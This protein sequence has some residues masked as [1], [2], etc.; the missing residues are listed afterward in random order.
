MELTSVASTAFAQRLAMQKGLCLVLIGSVVGA[1]SGSAEVIYHSGIGTPFSYSTLDLNG[2]GLVEITFISEHNS[3][4][5]LPSSSSTYGFGLRTSDTTT[6]ARVGSTPLIFDDR[7]AVPFELGGEATWNPKER[8][9]PSTANNYYGVAGYSTSGYG[10][11]YTSSD[12]ESIFGTEEGGILGV[13]FTSQAGW[14]LGW[15]RFALTRRG[16]GTPLGVNLVDYAYESTPQAPLLAGA[17]PEPISAACL[18]L[19]AVLVVGRRVRRT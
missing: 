18:A 19:G 6:L 8:V 13:R 9:V 10:A 4:T 2:D 15:L 3:S 5:D 11:S 7:E 16:D 1:V 17:V 14:H 12:W